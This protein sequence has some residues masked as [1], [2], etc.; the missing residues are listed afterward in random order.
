MCNV[1]VMKPGDLSSGPQNPHTKP[2]AVC[3]SVMPGLVRQRQD[4]FIHKTGTNDSLASLWL[5]TFDYLSLCS[6]SFLS[7]IIYFYLMGIDVLPTPMSV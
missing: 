5:V 2:A 3:T 1:P 6:L 4:L 7:K